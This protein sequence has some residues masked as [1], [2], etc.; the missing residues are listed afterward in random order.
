MILENKLIKIASETKFYGI[1]PGGTHECKIKNKICG[2][3]IKIAIYKNLKEIRYETNACIFTQASSA[4]LA[5][6][7]NKI[8]KFNEVFLYISKKI[9]GK[10]VYSNIKC[11]DDYDF[12]FN[13]QNK[14]RKECI[15]LWSKSV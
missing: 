10:K 8:K 14:N 4:I 7:F 13:K 11:F 3:E 1:K 2:A 15:F 12:F 9:D 5:N 6:N